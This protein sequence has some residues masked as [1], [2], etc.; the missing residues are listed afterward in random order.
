MKTKLIQRKN[1][2]QIAGGLCFLLFLL[3][4]SCSDGDSP[5]PTPEPET[6]LAELRAAIAENIAENYIKL[7]FAS[8]KT[9]NDLFIV[10][11]ENFTGSPSVENLNKLRAAHKDL[12]LSWQPAAIYQ[13]GPT[14]TNALRAAINTYPTDADLIESNVSAGT[15]TIGAIS[16]RAAEGLPAVDYLIN[17]TTGSDEDIIAS[18]IDD[19][20]RGDYLI[21]LVSYLDTKISVS[22]DQWQNGEFI[23]AFTATSANG[24]DVGSALGMLINAIDLH[25]Q[26]FLRDGKVAIPSGVRSAGIARPKATESYYGGFDRELLIAALEAYEGLFDGGGQSSILTY[27]RALDEGDLATNVA[28]QIDDAISL[29]NGLNDSFAQQI[30]DDNQQ[31]INVF[32]ELQELVTLI[33]SDVSSVIGITI[34]NQDVDGD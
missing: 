24:T 9:K 22:T 19:S 18:Y 12:W 20:A 28:Q 34:T 7:S 25:V 6:N 11:A 15:W 30:E 31:M 32:M 29:S 5:A 16:N 2:N 26:R 23:N 33:K 27:L 13:M 10:A 3:I 8:L 4:A 21:G 14:T 17:N 1:I